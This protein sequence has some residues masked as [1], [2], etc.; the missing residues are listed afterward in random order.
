[1][2]RLC[3]SACTFWG[4]VHRHPCPYI[5]IYIFEAVT[6]HHLPD[7]GIFAYIS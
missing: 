7:L 6:R 2:I 5:S 3:T 4:I 1:M